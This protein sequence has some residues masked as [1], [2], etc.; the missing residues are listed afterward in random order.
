LFF[1]EA[2]PG[3]YIGCMLANLAS[4]YTVYDI[5]LGSLA[6]L[7]AAIL[8]Y[9]TGRIIKNN[10][11]KVVIGGFFPIIINAFIIPAVWILAGSTDIV[12]WYQF[13]LMIL[14]EGVWIYALGIP[15]YFAI[16]ALQ[17]K[18]VKVLLPVVVA[19]NNQKKLKESN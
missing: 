10:I 3:L 18:G 9:I 16:L 8:T 7:L 17:K 5:L 6:T 14:N 19:K 1:V 2:I 4:M 13:A 15:F 12:Y 11:L